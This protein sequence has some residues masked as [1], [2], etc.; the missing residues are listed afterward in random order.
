MPFVRRCWSRYGRVNIFKD[1]D[2]WCGGRIVFHFHIIAF[3]QLLGHSPKFYL[4]KSNI[5]EITQQQ[6][7]IYRASNPASASIFYIPALYQ[8]TLALWNVNH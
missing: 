7:G 1:C 2:A 5:L 8:C 3:V 6:L 4:E